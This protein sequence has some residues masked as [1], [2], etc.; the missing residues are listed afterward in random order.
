MTQREDVEFHLDAIW[1]TLNPKVKANNPCTL[2]GLPGGAVLRTITDGRTM[3]VF[4]K[5]GAWL[6]VT[7]A[8]ST[9]YWCQQAQTTQV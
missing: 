4:E 9:I 1:V 7:K 2:H 6:R 3:D 5:S 8:P